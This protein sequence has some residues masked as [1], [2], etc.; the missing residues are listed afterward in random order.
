MEVGY[1]LGLAASHIRDRARFLG[2]SLLRVAALAKRRSPARA[3]EVMREVDE[4]L[5]LL[6]AE[7]ASL[8]WAVDRIFER[9]FP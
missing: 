9:P 6:K 4:Q 2:D 1:D 5:G 8:A 7:V 3:A